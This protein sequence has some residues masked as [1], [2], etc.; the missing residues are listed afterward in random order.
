VTPYPLCLLFYITAGCLQA[1]MIKDDKIILH[2]VGGHRAY[3]PLQDKLVSRLALSPLLRFVVRRA[4]G[5]NFP[6]QMNISS[7]EEDMKT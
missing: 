6:T 7:T 2:G 1:Y 5:R 4:V 3:P